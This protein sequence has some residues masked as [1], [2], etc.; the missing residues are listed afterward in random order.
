MDIASVPAL[1][2]LL[3][4]EAPN[5]SSDVG[6]P[7]RVPGPFVEVSTG[8]AQES[9]SVLVVPGDGTSDDPEN[10]VA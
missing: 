1:D 2:L 8:L 9:S 7:V 4:L 6:V 3:S 10:P 5:A